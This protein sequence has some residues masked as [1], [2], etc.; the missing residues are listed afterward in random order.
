MKS[1]INNKHCFNS[2]VSSPLNERTIA[3][4]ERSRNKQ[5]IFIFFLLLSTWT[6]SAQSSAVGSN[7]PHPSSILDV[8]S[9]D[10][11]LL[12]PRVTYANRPPSPSEG[13]M[14]FQTDSL[15]GL[16]VYDGTRW[17]NLVAGTIS[18]DSTYTLPYAIA[19]P[20]LKRSLGFNGQGQNAVLFA[21]ND[22]IKV[23]KNNL[24]FDPITKRMGVGIA[25]PQTAL[26]V[27]GSGGISVSTTHNGSG[28]TDWV[29]GNFGGISQSKRVLVGNKNGIATIEAV[30]NTGAPVSLQLN[31]DKTIFSSYTGTGD[32]I[33]VTDPNGIVH[34]TAVIAAGNGLQQVGANLK[35]GGQLNQHTA[36]HLTADTFAIDNNVTTPNVLVSN[37]NN[38]L[39]SDDF[40]GQAYTSSYN[41]SL[42]GI[43]VQ[44]LYGGS[45]GV[46]YVYKGT[47]VLSPPIITI[48]NVSFTPGSNYIPFN[49]VIQKDSTYTFYVIGGSLFFSNNSVPGQMI[50][51][52]GLPD[53]NY[54]LTFSL[55]GTAVL[56]DAITMVGADTD[57]RWRKFSGGSTQPITIDNEGNLSKLTMPPADHL[58]NH[59][60]TQPLVLNNNQIKN[61]SSS[62]EG[63]KLND[64]GF[65]SL[66]TTAVT[67]P[68][69]VNSP[70]G[71]WQ[72]AEFS[73]NNTNNVLAIGLQ[74]AE[75][76]VGSFTQDYSGANTLIVNPQ[77]PIIMG[78]L[79]GS[80]ERIVGVGNDGVLVATLPNLP[81]SATNDG[82]ISASDFQSFTAKMEGTTPFAS[83]T[84]TGLVS[85][86]TFTLFNH[87]VSPTRSIN[88]TLPLTSNNILLSADVLIGIAQADQTTN[89]YLSNFYWN[90]F[91]QKA[92]MSPLANTTTTG[93]LKSQDWTTFNNKYTLPT[94]K[95]VIYSYF[96]S[97]LANVSQLSFDHTAGR[98]GIGTSTPT[99]KVTVSGESA[100]R[101]RTNNDN[102]DWKAI[103]VGPN[104][105]GDRIVMGTLSANATLGAHSSELLAWDTLSINP[106]APGT[107]IILGG[108]KTAQPTIGTSTTVHNRVASVNGSIR[109]AVYSRTM[110]VP[111][112]STT[113]IIWEHG[114]GY[115]PVVI[116]SFDQNGAGANTQ[117]SAISYYHVNDGNGNPY[118]VVFRVK[119]FGPAST[120]NL[121]WIL[122]Y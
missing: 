45:N 80:G 51:Y 74:N 122:V 91:N 83:S 62:T 101:I 115:A 121:R 31:A 98:L 56:G 8:Q 120:G 66:G 119:N 17:E 36:F 50:N 33:L 35:L 42:T 118:S 37:P 14:I 64:A 63:I 16:Y 81:A 22:S 32:R 92:P 78:S 99:H 3:L 12:I 34:D 9:G 53:S 70:D 25:L 108:E 68:L 106:G 11:G 86:A 46:F 43:T 60:A 113:E 110:S 75:A 95:S 6:I 105:N 49:L 103:N 52:L 73:G 48:P 41:A 94:S 29:A 100:T 84:V 19:A 114:L 10:K 72:A 67:H 20:T 71:T 76:T 112:S 44:S 89:G 15:T 82:Y 4:V 18:N 69:T 2:L 96:G 47:G 24:N 1:I 109:Q 87:K 102:S 21:H 38:N 57:L 117:N 54:D 104:G 58:G 85:A 93:I 39:W 111:A 97:P 28:T 26:H 107:S 59:M 55:H 61:S 30:S 13:L 65:M 40:K 116:T 5:I 79:A 27:V 90:A 77:G 23:D 88:S 7:P